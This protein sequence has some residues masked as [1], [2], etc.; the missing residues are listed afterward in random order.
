LL[1]FHFWEPV[2]YKVD[3][4]DFPSDTHEKR[5]H[6]VGISETVGHAMTFKILTDNT[7]KVIHR[8]NVRS[9][10]NPD[11][12]NLR[13][14]PLEP[15]DVA[16]PIVKSR[17]DSADDGEILP[18]MPVI[19]PLELIGRTFLMDK[20]DGQRHRARILNV[21]NEE[22]I[23]KR[24][25]EHERELFRQPGHVQFVCSVNDDD[26][27]E[28]LSYN[29]LMGYIE[30]DE[31]QHQDEDGNAIWK[32]KRVIGHE[33]PFR[34]SN[35]EYKGSRYNVLVEWENGEIT[36]EPLS[37]FGKDN[38]VT[39]AVYAHEHRL[40]EEEGWKQFRAIAKREQKMLCM[41]NQSHIKATRNT[42]RYKFG[43]RIPRNYNEAILFDLRNDNT[44]WRD[45]TVLEMSQLA[46]YD[47]FKDMGH[48]DSASPLAGYKKIH[49]HLVY[50]VKHDVD[51]CQ[52]SPYGYPVGERTLRH[53]VFT[54]IM[55]RYLPC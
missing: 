55:H 40:L 16:N 35:P 27:E 32:F 4:S 9:A 30:K 25:D 10:L 43:Y 41:V 46:E 33:G 12:K 21:I 8:S 39:C 18:P 26:Y 34:P 14:D 54:W 17:H 7:L 45:A 6:F 19:D 31:Q 48:K 15:S 28:I 53:R 29:E 3:D 50:D 20:E 22:K 44:Q 1:C 47:T 24:I 36:S 37:I 52:R 23:F 2:Y 49:T 51:G 5:G 13:L 42:P 11:E 38:P